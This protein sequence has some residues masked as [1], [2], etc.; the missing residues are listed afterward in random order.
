MNYLSFF[1]NTGIFLRR[2]LV[3]LG[4]ISVLLVVNPAA[5]VFAAPINHV[6]ASGFLNQILGKT[7]KE[8]GAVERNIG[9]ASGQTEGAA[10]QVTGRIRQDVGRAQS[11]ASDVAS[12]TKK[13]V[14]RVAD[15]ADSAQLQVKGKTEK[16]IGKAQGLLDK[17]GNK[18][19]DTASNA[20]NS[21]KGLFQ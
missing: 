3:L 15:K 8:A 18:I 6:A 2:F 16:D 12:D 1:R 7:E 4:C 9:K 19:E 10:K 17:V 5:K 14:N 11:A 13:Q 20:S 21:V